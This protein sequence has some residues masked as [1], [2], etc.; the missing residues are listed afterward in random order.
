MLAPWLSYFAFGFAGIF[1]GAI[2]AV[3]GG[4]TLI[5]F[6]VLVAFGIPTVPANAT[7]AVALWPGSLASVWGYR[8]EAKSALRIIA[9]LTIPAVFGAFFGAW[10]LIHTPESLFRRAVPG[11]I[12]LATLLF[13]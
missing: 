9:I 11:L 8:V 3:A 1:A 12:L 7:N 13:W 10:A 6:P 4:G 5:S 2:N